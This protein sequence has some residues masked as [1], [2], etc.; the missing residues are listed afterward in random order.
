MVAGKEHH[1]IGVGI[2]G[3]SSTG[4]DVLTAVR[5]ALFMY[6]V[7]HGRYIIPRAILHSISINGATKICFP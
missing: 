3:C 2:G 7:R 4:H 1:G 5:I 6:I